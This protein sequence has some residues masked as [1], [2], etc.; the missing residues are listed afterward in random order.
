M[1]EDK[2]K[3]GKAPQWK[4]G[5]SGN[6]AGRPKGVPDK[7]GKFRRAIQEKSDELLKVVLDAALA[8]DMTALRLCM[9]RIA[10]P[11][12]PEA[13]P[14]ELG[15]P[16]DASPQEMAEKALAAIAKGEIDVA[17]GKLMIEA[18]ASVSA[19]TELPAILA[20]LEAL[21]GK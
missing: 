20:R 1:S 3:S 18:V 12:K 6:P 16:D 4:P 8:G 11:L 9:D 17:S 19:L 5:Q 14:I 21:E 13:A 10:P 7:R 15:L 2:P